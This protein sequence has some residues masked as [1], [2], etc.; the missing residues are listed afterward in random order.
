M[1]IDYV[2][3]GQKVP[4]ITELRER[5]NVKGPQPTN[6][7]DAKRAVESYK[8]IRGRYPLRYYK[9]SFMG[10]VNAAVRAGKYVHACI[11]YGKWNAVTA[12]S[13]D[14]YFTDGH[15]VGILG[16]RSRG[17]RVQWR[18]YD[19]LEDGR[20]QGIPQGPRWVDKADVVQAMEAFAGAK[21]RCYAGVFGGGQPR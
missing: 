9:K 19:P 17:G 20:R 5:G 11:H 16:Q 8:V 3:R 1:G 14:P 4:R 15:S 10:D 13:G 12:A 21:G 2:T 7:D 6:I 18:L